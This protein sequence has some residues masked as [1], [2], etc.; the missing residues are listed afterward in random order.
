MK[1]KTVHIIL[2]V[3]LMTLTVFAQK[4]YRVGTTAANFLEIGY[5]TS[6][7]A[8]GD[9]YVSSVKNVSAIYWNPAGLAFIHKNEA[10]FAYQPWVADISTAFVATGIRIAG[11]GTLGLHIIHAGYGDI[12]VTNM[13]AQ[14]GTGEMYSA[15]EYAFGITYARELT[16][17]FSFGATAKYI[18]SKIWHVS[19]SAL[20]VD[21]GV[22]VQTKFF[23]L[24]GQR[25]DGLRIGMSISNYGSRM[26]YDGID[27]VYPIDPLPDENGNYKDVPG[28]YRLSYWELPLIF[29][30]GTSLD[31]IKMKHHVL[32][33]EV[34]ALHPNN[35]AES[36]NVGGQ[37]AFKI[38]QTG[39]FFLRAGYKGLFMPES[40]Y[41]F[42][43]GIGMVKYLMNNVSLKVDYAY[44]D[45]GILGSVHSYSIGI[46]F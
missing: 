9:A 30:I 28:Q 24:T 17:W 11:I 1:R 29:R 5:G 23:S 42:T 35:N 16:N 2:T 13:E 27:L 4:P 43:V 19:A 6:G 25:S 3:L 41:G 45:V 10:I 38:P 21:L 37:Y 36:V 18:T 31:V 8:M 7:I 14:E 32:T 15:D 46:L 12:P 44:R 33:F 39:E 26:R 22:L 34:N 40:Q 20:A